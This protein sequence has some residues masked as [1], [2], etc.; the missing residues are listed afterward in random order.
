MRTRILG[1]RSFA[2]ITACIGLLAG[3]TL[4]AAPIPFEFQDA[5]AC[6]GN[7][8]PLGEPARLQVTRDGKYLNVT[9][10]ANFGC[11]THAGDASVEGD[12]FLV[13]LSAK[14]ILNDG[15]L[16]HCKC[17]RELKY[18]FHYP[19]DSV[20]RGGFRFLYRQDGRD[21]SKMLTLFRVDEANPG[22]LP[23]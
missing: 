18:R 20:P 17:T 4:M 8:I 11:S 16:M 21:E 10:Q 12:H 3:T 7:L 14:T 15:P 6:R 2:S 22:A 5:P 9:V 23:D 19:T 13:V 1:S